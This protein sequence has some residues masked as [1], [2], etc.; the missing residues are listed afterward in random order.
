MLS[1][2]SLDE[3]AEI[4]F[5]FYDFD[6]SKYITR[7]ELVILLTNA[8]T[9]LN[10]MAK[11]DPPKI[12]EIEKE[13]DDF[14]TKSDLNS[15]NKITLKEFKS[16]LKKD[17]TIL[18][19]LMNFNIA[20]ME[21]MGTDFGGGDIP[22]CDSD[23]EREINPPELSRNSKITNAK[24]G[25]DF[26]VQE[27][28]GGLFTLDEVGGGDEFMAVKPWKGVIDNSVPSDYKPSKLDGAEPDAN[29]KLEYV[30]GYRC[31]DVRNNLRYTND[32]HFIY[33]TAALGI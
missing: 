2:S 1:N 28:E 24:Q 17:P 5:D 8:L 22:E 15:D 13:T 30:Y 14:F 19:I 20:K 26:Q 23:L 25:V 21:D 16:Y 31:H 7:D 29:L 4:L 3:K 18:N 6:K 33:H 11:R 12:K 32:D 27:A 9:A 10:A